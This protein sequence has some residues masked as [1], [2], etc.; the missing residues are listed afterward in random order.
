L[1]V[2]KPRSSCVRHSTWKRYPPHLEDPTRG[3]AGR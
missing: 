1:I 3:A 2:E